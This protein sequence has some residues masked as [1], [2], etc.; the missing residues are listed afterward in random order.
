MENRGQLEAA[1]QSYANCGDAT[2]YFTRIAVVLDFPRRRHAIWMRFIGASPSAVLELRDEQPTRLH[3]FTGAD[4]RRWQSSLRVYS[5]L[6]Y[7]DLWPGVD[8]MFRPEHGQ[9]RYLIH[10]ARASDRTRARFDFAGAD[11]VTKP[12]GDAL[13]IEI[14]G[15]D[16]SDR[17]TTT[18][19]TEHILRW[20]VDAT[21]EAHSGPG[22]DA[23]GTL[24]WSTFLGGSDNDYAHGLD[25]DAVDQPVV[26]GYALSTDFPTTPGAYDST[27][28]SGYDVFV[29]KFD[30]TGS[31]LLWA[32]F[33]GGSQEDRPFALALDAGARVL[34]AGH[35]FSADFPTTAG[36]YDRMLNGTR[37]VFVTMLD[38]SGASLRW[39]T[40]LGGAAGERAW[41]LA[42]TEDGRAVIA[43]E[44]GSADFPTTAG[45]H[46]TTIGGSV[47]GF[48]SEFDAQGQTLLWS[49]F[50]GGSSSDWINAVVLDRMHCP[51]TTGT[52][53]SSDYPVTPSAF[54]HSSN[55]GGDAFVTKLAADGGSV[56]YSTYLGGSGTDV[57][58]A[59]G[60]NRR[61]E[62]V[63]TGSTDSANFPVTSGAFD[64]SYN[65]AGDIFIAQ[66]D[67]AGAALPWSTFVGGS[68]LDEAFA[69]ILD[70]EGRPIVSGETASTDFPTSWNAFDR[71]YGGE[72]D[73]FVTQIRANGDSLCWS[74]FLGGRHW[75]SGWDFALDSTGN[76]LLTGP[77]RSGD[78]PTS[79]GAFDRVYNGGAE[80]VFLAR[81]EIRTPTA[82]SPMGGTETRLWAGPN[83]FPGAVL[84]RFHLVQPE[85]VQLLVFDAAGRRV[86]TWLP[87]MRA[88]GPNSL[89][90]SGCEAP[91]GLPVPGGV[92]WVRLQTPSRVLQTKVIRLR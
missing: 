40:Y 76:P 52:T 70:P 55:G 78:F 24:S 49:T 34:I 89:V 36:A 62:T 54:D 48:V 71:T 25:V 72:Q 73:A 32:T 50:L 92:Y 46:D 87:E 1:V 20:G 11:R 80:D 59:V 38:A 6:V 7:H 67:A 28:S 77:T 2:I 42:L 43:G 13:R 9:L 30:A 44:T 74:S 65:G 61:G 79:A 5:E 41:G 3:F 39:S 83:P 18:A 63:L 66:F 29:A 8:V 37:D 60:L 16:L 19:G 31:T 84:L 68:G 58:Y 88:A 86:A 56:A 35:T 47:D 75:D 4:P 14:P 15:S 53:Y 51:V 85:A 64:V 82:V 17:E 26:T 45:A 33:L 23:A 21:S 10:A 27:H 22:P 81:F 57:A 69:L 90:W 12:T 91:N